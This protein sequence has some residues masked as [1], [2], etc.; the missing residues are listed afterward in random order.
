MASTQNP[1][2]S[3]SQCAEDETDEG[4]NNSLNPTEFLKM[5]PKKSILKTKQTSFDDLSHAILGQRDLR[6]HSE[7]TQK[8]HFDEVYFKLIILK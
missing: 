7:E 1:G 6:G 5:R 2:A 4:P 3:S 8:A